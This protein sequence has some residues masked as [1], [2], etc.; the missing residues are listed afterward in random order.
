MTVGVNIDSGGTIRLQSFAK[1]MV[2]GTR[3]NLVNA[4]GGIVCVKQE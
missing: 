2:N 3:G 4:H 1:F